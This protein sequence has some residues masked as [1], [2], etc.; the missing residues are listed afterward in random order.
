MSDASDEG[1]AD[2]EELDSKITELDELDAN[3]TDLEESD[4]TRGELLVFTSSALKYV[5]GRKSDDFNNKY[6][7]IGEKFHLRFKMV[8]CN[9]ALVKTVLHSYGFEQCSTKNPSCNIIWTGS[10]LR[11]HALR[12]LASWQRVNHFPK[13]F[14]LTRKDKLYE[15]IGRA[16]KL[17]G[18]SFN[19]I[20]EFFVTPKDYH[21]FVDCFNAQT[22][23][24][25]P[26]IVKPVASSRGIGIFIAQSPGEIPLGSPMLVS[27]Y[28]TNPYLLDGHK[29]DLRLYVMVTSFSP[30]VAYIYRQGLARFASEKYCSN[31]KSYQHQFSHLTNYSV[32][33]NNGRFVKLV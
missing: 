25:K 1:I 32:N 26:F 7:A 33:K 19:I 31:A 23:G 18:D 12:S 20:P 17:F 22:H 27:R 8:H 15:C 6:V 29:F 13:S 3:T 2:V 14:L 4:A 30:L 11:P 16:Q 28:I 9:P 5:S 10:H 24:L 21:K